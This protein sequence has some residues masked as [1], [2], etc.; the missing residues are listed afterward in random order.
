MK[1]GKIVIKSILALIIGS[2]IAGCSANSV[3]P[4]KQISAEETKKESTQKPDIELTG[5]QLTFKTDIEDLTEKSIPDYTLRKIDRSYEGNE[6]LGG[7]IQE[8]GSITGITYGEMGDKAV[9]IDEKQA[10]AKAKEWISTAFKGFDVSLLDDKEPMVSYMRKTI[11]GDEEEEVVIG[12]RIEYRNEYDEVKI[13]YEGIR[14]M[15]DDSGILYGSIEWNEF[16][17]AD[18]SEHDQLAPKVDFEQ[19]K[20]LLANAITKE[21]KEL[22]FDEN[23]EDARMAN[24]VELVFTGNGADEYIPSW[25]YEMEDG[26][27]YY[28]NC[29]NGQV[30]TP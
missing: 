15:L 6:E 16:K 13:Q 26:R 8:S 21:N 19:S 10:V 25:Y 22:G 3:P 9:S 23:N 27:T 2:V 4:E 5:Q 30:S 20:I 24:H 12:Y 17:E 1:S 11:L 7:R 14:V 29:I 18:P 28:V